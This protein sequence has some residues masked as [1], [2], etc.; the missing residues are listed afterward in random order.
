MPKTLQVVILSILITIL[1]L[2]QS[3]A[4][5]ASYTFSSVQVVGLQHVEQGTVLS[6]A[7]IARG[8]PMTDADLNDAYQRISHS[9]LFQSVELRPEGSKLVITVKEFPIINVINFE[10]NKRLK[11]ED[12]AKFIK[13]QSRKVYSPA[14]AEADAATITEAYRANKRYAVIVTPKII[15]RSD[16][17]VD[18]AFV[19]QEGKPVYVDRLSFVGNRAFSDGRLRQVLATKQAGFL[20]SFITN[21]SYSP[22]R[23]DQ[24]KQ[25]LS[26]FYLSRGYIDFRVLDASSQIDSERNGFYLT[27]SVSEGQSYTIANSYASTDLKDVDLK[28]LQSKIQIRP[29]TTYSPT[30]VDTTVTRMENEAVR[31]GYNFVRVTPKII[32]DDKNLALAINFVVDRGP[33]VFVERIDIEGNSTTQDRVIRR[34]F[35]T[36]E[37]DPFNPREIK[38]AS[39]R[40][41]A[42]GFFKDVQVDTKAGSAPD[43]AVVDVNVTEQSTGSLSFGGSYGVGSGFG[44]VVGFSE[45]NFLGRGQLLSLDLNTT[46]DNSNSAFTFVEPALL[47]R[48]LKFAVTGHATITTHNYANYDTHVLGLSPSIE[49][50]VSPMGRLELRYS[51]SRASVKNVD[52]NASTII[53]R[54]AGGAYDQRAWLY[55]QFLYQP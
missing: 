22:D 10:G 35:R 46:K 50:P 42:L 1:A 23:I 40:I 25:L 36:S 41:K 37:G 8:K 43:K 20:R 39:D 47:G 48:D 19:I 15:P 31:L 12:L 30:I 44:I 17:R 52:A 34:Q 53:Q 29:G 3:P 16:N 2:V 45:S 49:F 14:Q 32:R 55:L 21:D 11:S 9:G 5:A 6:Y 54:E 51:L 27:F 38:A 28:A 13:S 24:D 4:Q 7:G 26:D 18:L 33:K